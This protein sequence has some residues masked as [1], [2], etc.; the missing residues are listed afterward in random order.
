MFQNAR[1]TRLSSDAA[2]CLLRK[3]V[4]TAGK[5]CASLR[6]KRISPHVLRHTAAMELLQAGVDAP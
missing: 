1:G 4:A 5:A 6:K 2:Q 3:H